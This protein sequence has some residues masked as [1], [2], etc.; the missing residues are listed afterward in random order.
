MEKMDM[1]ERQQDADLNIRTEG[2][3]QGFHDSLHH[4]RYEPTPYALLS[5]LFAGYRLSPSDRLVDFGCGKGRLAFYVHH[6]F[7]AETV[8]VEIDQGL[9]REAMQN[10]SRYEKKAPRAKGCIRFHCTFAEEYP[11]QPQDNRF[12]FFNP[13]SVQIFMKVVLN[14]LK[15]VERA[16][17]PVELILFFPSDDYIEFLEYRTGFLR[18]LEIPLP[19]A[20]TLFQERFL[21]YR[22]T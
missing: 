14:V 17:R 22:L 15:S 1:N 4:N 21:V 7:G 20:E 10:L 16:P 19:G 5:E 11:V 9:F 2:I 6:L 12:Y 13:F 3:Q 8:G 18:V